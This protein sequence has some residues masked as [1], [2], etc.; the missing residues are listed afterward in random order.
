[1]PGKGRPWLHVRAQPSLIA[2]LRVLANRSRLTLS[3][4]AR[5]AL[6][7]HVEQEVQA[8]NKGVT[9]PSFRPL[10]RAV[11]RFILAVQGTMIAGLP[12]KERRFELEE[13]SWETLQEYIK[14]AKT[15]KDRMLRLLAMRVVTAQIR[16]MLA[17]LD[18]L[19]KAHVDEFLDELEKARFEYAKQNQASGRKGKG[20]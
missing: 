15:Q 10:D 8:E 20:T 7:K 17:V 4:Y 3:D 9:H 5:R 13:L 1:M 19:D 16:A 6:V 12:G 18:S 2:A 11:K 14:Y